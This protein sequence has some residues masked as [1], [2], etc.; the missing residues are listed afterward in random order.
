MEINIKQFKQD[1]L[2]DDIKKKVII[3]S[4]FII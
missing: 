4:K 3:Y 2:S 1:N